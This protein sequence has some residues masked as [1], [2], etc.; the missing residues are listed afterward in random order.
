M[1]AMVISLEPDG[2]YAS[3]L[4]RGALALR[5]F[6]FIISILNAKGIRKNI[7]YQGI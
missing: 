7:P 2:L 6:L 3:D 5:D 4:K 1:R